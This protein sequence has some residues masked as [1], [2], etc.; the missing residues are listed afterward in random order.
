MSHFKLPAKTRFPRA[1]RLGAIASLLTIAI[2]WLWAHEG[3][4]P[5]P[6]KGAQVDVAKGLIVLSREAR[7]ALDVQVAEIADRP[8]GESVLAYATLV[9]P[10]QRH[11]FA[12]SRLPGRITKLHVA[13]GQVVEAGQLL[14][15]V[16]GVELETLQLE[17]LNAQNDVRLSEKVL[18]RLQEGRESIAAQSV[19]DAETKLEQDRNGLEIARSKWLSLGLTEQSLAALLRGGERV[20]AL[21]IR[22]P[23][24]GTIIHADLTVGRIVQTAEHLFEIVSL[25][26]VWARIGVL[27]KDL[28]RIDVGQDAELRLA[29]YPGEVFQSKIQ[30]KGLRLDPQ[31]HLNTVWAD[32]TNA[33][34]QEPRLLPGMSGHCRIVLPPARN[35]KTIPATALINNGLDRFVLV[36]EASAKGGSE[37]RKKNVVILR[38]TPESVEIE[39]PD[40]FPG[41]RVVTRGSHELGDFFQPGVLRLSP[42]TVR[43]IGLRTE[44]VQPQLI[45]EVVE[46]QG[47]VD[48]PPERRTFASTLLGGTLRRIAVERGQTV[49]AGDVIAE[50]ASLE[51]Q[52][53][54]LELLK[55]HLTHQ[56]LQK[57]LERMRANER[58][59]PQ[60]RIVDLE[61]ALNASRNRRESLRRRLEVVGLSTSQIDDLLAKKQLAE[62]LPIRAPIAGTV[63]SFDKVLGQTLVAEESLAE[64]HDLSHPWVQAF[65]SEGDINNVR[66]GQPA[67]IR[68]VSDPGAVFTGKVTRSGR[69]FGAEDRT[70]SIWI[71]FDEIP[72]RP[73]RHNQLAEVTLTIKQFARSLAVPRSALIRDG[74]NSFV[75]VRKPDGT[76]DRRMVETGPADDRRIAIVRGLQ[77]GEV[78]AVAGTAGLQMAYASLR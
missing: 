20:A 60:R 16:A 9:A 73:L 74:T 52:N 69:V 44:T 37:F 4:Q 78:V 76:F 67:R 17:L 7:S 11:G 58:G 5:L 38:Q 33:A 51:L 36:E 12:S 28:E 43:A 26:Q 13:P 22:S 53:L 62:T 34:G 65:I 18:A 63:V 19:F 31:T 14:A 56:L 77:T 21:P 70:L 46:L 15:E 49:H 25:S 1:A 48:I 64:I 42:E 29:A 68:F 6:T 57:Q 71:D 10:W 23:I 75:F 66:I 2:T 61:S 8:L 55:E 47:S 45:E 35:A 32:F 27:E 72:K 54:Q 3:H 41:D 30:V 50:V 24:S 39:S 59:F 40:L